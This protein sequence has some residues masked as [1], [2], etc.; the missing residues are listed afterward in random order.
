MII[1][2]D[3]IE[4]LAKD[5][6]L[7]FLD[8]IYNSLK[9]EG[10]VLINT[11]NSQSL[12]SGKIRYCDFAHEQGFTTGSLSQVLRVGKFKNITVYG[13]EPV[14]YDVRSFMR[15]ILWQIVK[16]ILKAYLVIESGTGRGLWKRDNILE[17]RMFAVAQK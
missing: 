16:S 17:S 2:N 7:N 9:R 4:H 6:V 8:S 10:H 3:I 5:E 14:I 11:L 15:A 1:A 12:F 13:E